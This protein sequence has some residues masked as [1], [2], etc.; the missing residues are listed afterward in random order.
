MRAKT[1]NFQRGVDPKAAMGIGQIELVYKDF[2][3]GNYDNYDIIASDESDEEDSY[4]SLRTAERIFQKCVKYKEGENDFDEEIEVRI[5]EGLPIISTINEYQILSIWARN[6]DLEKIISLIKNKRKKSIKE[7]QN[8]QRGMD[9]KKSLDIGLSS[10]IPKIDS[11][12]L[13]QI[14]LGWD[15]GKNEFSEDVYQSQM[16]GFM[17]DD[18]VEY[19]KTLSHLKLVGLALRGHIEFG[20]SFDWKEK[21]DM[22]EYLDEDA[23]VGKPY[24][25][26]ASPESDA[27]SVVWSDI[28]LPNAEPIRA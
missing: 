24:A 13:E 16:E 23:P 20:E 5:F 18:P 8:F 2:M 4:I 10:A 22:E 12:D 1:I 15:F 28:E 17:E 26:N 25:Y 19:K 9:P 14:E 21:D 3:E 6:E 7:S 27:Y 11:Y